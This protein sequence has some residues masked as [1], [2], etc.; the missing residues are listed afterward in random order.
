MT[1]HVQKTA[2]FG[3]LVAAVF[4]QAMLHSS[5][6]R[7]VSLMAT[8]AVE[9]ILRTQRIPKGRCNEALKRARSVPAALPNPAS[10]TH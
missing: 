3:D 7:E 8:Q 2:Q 10:G 4:D 5:D 9:H 1:S 6:P